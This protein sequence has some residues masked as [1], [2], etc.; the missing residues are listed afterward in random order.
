MTRRGTAQKAAADRDRRSPSGLTFRDLAPETFP[1]Y[2]RLFLGPGG[3]AWCWC[4]AYRRERSAE[5]EIASYGV[6]KGGWK[7]HNRRRIR[8]L[9]RERRAHGVLVYQGE[10][11]V[12]WCAYGRKEDF[13]RIDRGRFYRKLPPPPENLWRIVCF[14]V[15]VGHRR[16]G[17][18]K[19]ALKH[20]LRTIRIRG[21][22]VVEGY[23][24]A[25]EERHAN[26]LWFGTISM[27]EREGFRK[28]ARMGK[29]MLVRKT[30]RAAR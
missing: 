11:P 7:E 8:E 25:V 1:D 21:G 29:S 6:R 17:V 12:G 28:V 4:M 27:F 23:P 16:R 26:F 9:V 13:P 19:S 2:E 3:N 10:E 30:V 24:V 22:G 14:V 15:A 5:K 18:A 20:V